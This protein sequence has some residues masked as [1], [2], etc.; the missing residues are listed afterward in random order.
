MG[1]EG[2]FADGKQ[3]ETGGQ[4]QALLRPGDGEVDAPI[5]HLELDGADGAD[6]IDEE[7]RGVIGGVERGADGGDIGGDAGGG[8]VMGGEDGLD[9]VAGIGGEAGGVILDR[10]ALAPVDVDHVDIKTETL[11]HVDPKH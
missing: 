8:L 3:A 6:A 9:R 11:G 2:L 1:G 7:Q 5:L 10:H 4:H